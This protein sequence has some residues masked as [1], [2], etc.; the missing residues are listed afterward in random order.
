MVRGLTLL[1]A[2]ILLL[3]LAGYVLHERMRATARLLWGISLALI[4][5]L[6]LLIAGVL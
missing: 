2:V 6:V 5:L 1:F 3:A 4:V